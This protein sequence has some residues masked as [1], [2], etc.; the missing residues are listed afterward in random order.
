MVGRPATTVTDNVDRL[1]GAVVE[2]EGDRYTVGLLATSCGEPGLVPMFASV[3]V[4]TVGGLLL[5]V[6]AGWWGVRRRR[7]G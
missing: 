4:A 2:Y 7:S 5:L 3:G 1:N 6:A